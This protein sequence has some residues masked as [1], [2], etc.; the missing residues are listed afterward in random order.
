MGINSFKLGLAIGL[1]GEKL[2]LYTQPPAYVWDEETGELI[3]N[4]DDGSLGFLFDQDAFHLT[5]TEE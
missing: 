3:I 4:R 1:R 5:V 2:N